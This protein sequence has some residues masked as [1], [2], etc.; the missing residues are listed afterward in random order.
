MRLRTTM[1]MVVL[2]A[3]TAAAHADEW[4]DERMVRHG[5]ETS[6]G[7]ELGARTFGSY[8]P[9]VIGMSVRHGLRRDATLWY[10]GYQLSMAAG[11]MDGDER[12]HDA[13]FQRLSVG[14][15][16]EIIGDDCDAG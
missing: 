1:V 15:L 6:T 10:A 13:V 7:I 12:Q 4:D 9:G 11:T 8:T 3:A 5:R 14:V 2:L 16:H